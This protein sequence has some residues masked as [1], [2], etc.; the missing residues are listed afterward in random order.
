MSNAYY[1]SA[2]LPE[3]RYKIS[4]YCYNKLMKITMQPAIS[5][6][7]YIALSNGDSASWVNPADEARYNQEVERCGCVIVGR[8]TYEE[9]KD[10]FDSYKNVIIFVC[11]NNAAYTDTET[12]K[13][14]KGSANEIIDSI[15]NNYDFSELVVCGGGEVNGMLAEAGLV[16]EI[17]VSI[18]PVVL[19]QGIPL[20]GSFK[21]ALKLELLSTNQDI[22]GVT[23]NHYQVI[24]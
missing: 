9:Y 1:Y 11:T 22:A 18:Q 7:G 21:P 16:D 6:D 12:V 4:V 15:K 10:G 23:Q 19:G 20:F 5:L 2:A 3:E 17:V 14:V 8:T 13:F 24:K